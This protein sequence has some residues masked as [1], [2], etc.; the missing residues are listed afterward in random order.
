MVH[1]LGRQIEDALYEIDSIRRFAS[2]GSVT[3]V[4][5]DETSILNFRRR[6]ENTS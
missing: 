1:L 5:S 2:F 3:E 4:L 6:L